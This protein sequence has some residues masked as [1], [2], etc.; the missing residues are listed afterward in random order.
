MLHLI[1]PNGSK[2]KANPS[3]HLEVTICDLKIYAA[4]A[5]FELVANCD[6]CHRNLRSQIAT[7]S[8]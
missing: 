1:H 3:F 6:G 5:S 8:L 2:Y 4:M 7:S